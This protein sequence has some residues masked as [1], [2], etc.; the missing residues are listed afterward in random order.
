M[1][2]LF[3]CETNNIARVHEHLMSVL[4]PTDKPE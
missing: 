4:S 2:R 1:S 3:L